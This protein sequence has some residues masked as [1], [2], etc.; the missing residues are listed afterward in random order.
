MRSRGGL[1]PVL[2]TCSLVC[3]HRLCRRPCFTPSP[4]LKQRHACCSVWSAGS[5]ASR[6]S[7]HSHTTTRYQRQLHLVLVRTPPDH[8]RRRWAV[9]RGIGPSLPRQK[10]RIFFGCRVVSLAMSGLAFS[11]ARATSLPLYDIIVKCQIMSCTWST[12]D[13][14]RPQ[15]S[16]YPCETVEQSSLV[17]SIERSDHNTIII[18]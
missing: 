12:T 18:K 4:W 13:P 16:D 6:H 8:R 11:V 17:H 5:A 7:V 10:S 14:L 1:S 3:R 9:A 2:R 15:L